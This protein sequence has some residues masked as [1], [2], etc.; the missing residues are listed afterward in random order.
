MEN[1]P[2]IVLYKYLYFGV[3][4]NVYFMCIYDIKGCW[5]LL[6]DCSVYVHVSDGFTK[7]KF[8]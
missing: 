2:K 1:R 4:Y 8:G 5:S 3:L 6:F 7:K